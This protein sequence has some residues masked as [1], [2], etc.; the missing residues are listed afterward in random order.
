MLEPNSF[1]RKL[2]NQLF[3]NTQLIQEKVFILSEVNANYA[4]KNN[5]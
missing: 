4:I 2:L 1:E 3:L 5:A